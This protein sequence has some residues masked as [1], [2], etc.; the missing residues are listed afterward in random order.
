MKR[1]LVIAISVLCALTVGVFAT[2]NAS[3]EQR[4]F[5]CAVGGATKEYI[6][7]HCVTNVGSG[8]TRSSELVV[9]SI[10]YKASNSKTQ[11]ETLANQLMVLHGSIAGVEAEVQCTTVA[12]TG[13]LTNAAASVTG[14]GTY[15]YS[16]C[17][18][19][20][21]AGRECVVTGG[22]IVSEK[23]KLTTVGQA[24]NTVKISPFEGT[25][26][27]S[28]SI[29]SCKKNIPPTNSYPIT[30]SFVAALS[31]AT[32]S[33]APGTL[34]GQGTLKWAGQVAG[35]FGSTTKV[36]GAGTPLIFK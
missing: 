2:A 18:V 29:A 5:R 31:G 10:V 36:D 30:G 27:A 19:T 28:V 4:I 7:E 26:M 22:K 21:P 17:T 13:E 34:T 3:A 25:Q 35:W 15:E 9:G 23:L 24:A 1:N 11:N 14:S 6:D 20:K 33:V 12:E 32:T 8:G 16:G